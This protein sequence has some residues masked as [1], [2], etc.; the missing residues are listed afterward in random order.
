MTNPLLDLIGRAEAG[1]NYNAYYAHARNEDSPKLT[2]MTM[3]S[4]RTWQDNYI[5]QGSKSSAVGKYQIIR[6]TFDAI[7]KATSIPVTALFS[8]ETQDTMCMFLLRKRGYNK[9]I[10][11]D[12]M[13]EE[14]A[15]ELCKE[16]ASLPV[17]GGEKH[18]RSYYAGDGLNK[19]LVKPEE[20]LKVLGSLRNGQ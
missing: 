15:N 10:N 2:A 3:K 6:K 19:A 12:I 20:I 16:W 5:R 8:E 11:G 17:I 1:G 18:G 9:F 14:F 13:A 7:M 4:V